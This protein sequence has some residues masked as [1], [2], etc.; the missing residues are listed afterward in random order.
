MSFIGINNNTN[1]YRESK[2]NG[3]VDLLKPKE[4]V[5]RDGSMGSLILEMQKE[6]E[7]AE[8]IARKI[9]RG[10]AVN[11]EDMKYLREKNPNLLDK[12]INVN[13]ERKILEMKISG[14][15]SKEEAQRI[16]R[17]AKKSAIDISLIP[18]TD[19]IAESKLNLEAIKESIINTNLESRKYKDKKNGIDKFA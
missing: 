17:S 8:E 2:C 3:V 14:A 18:G 15:K 4:E 13:N 1:M 12:A 5:K 10:K 11:S 19:N 6:K 16:I 7:K 9:A